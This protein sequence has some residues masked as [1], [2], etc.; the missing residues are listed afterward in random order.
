MKLHS[1]YWRYDNFKISFWKSSKQRKM[2]VDFLEE[3]S[4]STHSIFNIYETY[5]NIMV[6]IWLYK[7][8]LFFWIYL[9]FIVMMLN[10]EYL[11]FISSFIS[12]FS[13]CFSSCFWKVLFLCYSIIWFIIISDS[14]D[15]E[16]RIKSFGCVFSFFSTLNNTKLNNTFLKILKNTKNFD[17]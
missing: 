14:F 11:R 5:N 9:Y 1:E 13:L 4:S 10:D 15:L 8:Y 17:F 7:E 2:I 3:T 6:F 16:N 12:L